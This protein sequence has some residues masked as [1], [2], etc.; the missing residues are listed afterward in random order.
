MKQLY[1]NNCV[2]IPT[3]EMVGWSRFLTHHFNGVVSLL[4]LLFIVNSNLF[5]QA[6][7]SFS[8]NLNCG[9]DTYCVD[10]EI[11]A[12]SGNSFDI[13]TSSFLVTYDYNALSYSSYSPNAF[14][15]NT[16]GCAGIWAAHKTDVYESEGKFGLTLRLLNNSGG[17]TL[18]GNTPTV[19]GT[20]CFD[21]NIQ[22]AI[23]NITFDNTNSLINSN[24]PDDGSMPISI[25]SIDTLNVANSL[26]C[27]CS[28]VGDPCDDLNVFTINDQYDIYCN[29]VGTLADV[30]LD[31]I[32]D[33][34]DNCLDVFYE[35]ENGTMNWAGF[36]NNQPQ[37]N[38]TGFVDWASK[39]TDTLVMSIVI[40]SLSEY[41]LIF[42]Y[43][44]GDATNIRR[45]KFF[46]DST[47]ITDTLAFPPTGGWNIWGEINLSDSLTADTHLLYL[48]S[49]GSVHGP[50]I[51]RIAIS[52]CGNCSM[53]GTPCDD[54]DPCTDSDTYDVDCNCKGVYSDSDKDG[55]CDNQDI[56]P[57][58]DDNLDTDMDGVPDAC[59]DCDNNLNGTSCDDGDPC[60]INDVYDVNC[61]CAGT[62]TGN[63]SDGDGVCDA[64]DACPGFDDNLDEDNDG[65]P[66]DCDSCNDLTVG[67]PCDDGNPCTILDVVTPGCGCGGIPI[68]LE[69]T[70]TIDTIKCNGDLASIDILPEHM[71]GGVYY[72]WNT[73]AYT[74]DLTNL[75]PGTYI[76][77]A[78]DW[79]NCAEVD[80]FIITEPSPI[81]LSFA[82]VPSGGSNGEIDLTVSGGNAPY[83]YLWEDSTMTQDLSGL[84]SDRFYVTVTD[85]L[86][87]NKVGFA[88]VEI[89][90]MCVDTLL[91][92]EYGTYINLQ[93]HNTN[94]GPAMDGFIRFGHNDAHSSVTHYYDF[95]EFGKYE[96]NIRHAEK[97]RN[98][99]VNIYL[100]GVLKHSA[101]YIPLTGSDSVFQHVTFTID[102]IPPGV[103]SIMTERA[104]TQNNYPRL[105]YLSICKTATYDCAPLE[106]TTCND[107]NPCTLNDLITACD[108]VGIYTDSDG[109]G[110]CD[111]DDVCAGFDDSI[112]SDDD[113]IPDGCDDCYA[114]KYE[115]ED[116][117]RISMNYRTTGSGWTG[118]GYVDYNS[119]IGDT[120]RFLINAELAGNYNIDLRYAI[121]KSDRFLDVFVNN[122]KEID[123]LFFPNTGSSN[124]KWESLAFN[125][126]LNAG[127]NI[128]ELITDGAHGPN[129]DYL[130]ICL[131]N[132]I[133]TPIIAKENNGFEAG[134]NNWTELTFNGSDSPV[135]NESTTNVLC[136]LKSMH[137]SGASGIEKLYADIDFLRIDSVYTLHFYAAGD[138]A[139]GYIGLPD[140]ILNGQYFTFD[141]TSGNGDFT[142]QSITFTA[143]APT[144]RLWFEF[145]P[146][147]NLYLDAFSFDNSN[148]FIDI[149]PKA[150]LSGAF[151]DA[152]NLM[153]D[154]LRVADLIPLNE[155]YT[156]LNNF[157][158][159]A[160]GGG[161]MIQN[162]VLHTTGND[163]IVDWVM[164]ELRDKNDSTNVLATK[165]AL[166]QRDGDIVGL[167][168]FSN[169]KF[170][171]VFTDDYYF[172]VRHR[173]HAG[174]MTASPISLGNGVTSIDFTN[175]STPTFGLNAQKNFEGKTALWS[176]DVNGDG[177]T[178]YNGWVSD[179]VAILSELNLANPDSVIVNKYSNADVNMDGEVKYN[180]TGNDREIILNQVGTST[181]NNIKSGNIPNLAFSL[182]SQNL[183]IRAKNNGSSNL[184]DVQLRCTT[185]PC[186]TTADA[187]GDLVFGLKWLNNA[188]ITL[189]TPTNVY[190]IGKS[191]IELL[192]GGYE[193]QAF[194]MTQLTDFPQNWTL[195]KWRTVT[196]LS[197]ENMDVPSAQVEICE[198][199]FLNNTFPN[200]NVILGDSSSMDYTPILANTNNNIPTIDD[201]YVDN[202]GDNVPNAFDCDPNDS[203]DGIL[204]IN[205]N[206]LGSGIYE[207]NNQIESQAIV[208][209]STDATFRAG[210][211]KLLPG[212]KVDNSQFVAIATDV[213]NEL[214]VA[215]VGA[216]VTCE[217]ESDGTATATATDG[218]GNYSYVW[219][220]GATTANLTDLSVG[221]YS[222]TIT[223][224]NGIIDSASVS[225]N[226]DSTDS[227]NDLITDGCDCDPNDASDGLTAVSDNPI[228]DSTYTAP[229]KLTSIGVIE[230]DTVT[231]FK[232]TRNILLLPGFKAKS[233]S[234]L[235]AI[236]EDVC[237]PPAMP[238]W[239]NEEDNFEDIQADMTTSDEKTFGHKTDPKV[240]F[241]PNPTSDYF[242]IRSEETVRG[243]GIYDLLGQEIFRGVGAEVYLADL[244]SGTYVVRVF[245][246]GKIVV[247]LIVKE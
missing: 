139:T 41:D 239:K 61:N 172:A 48:I 30:D 39:T 226:Y 192:S 129:I 113:G 110:V 6:E 35:A 12:T 18:V 44:N 170:R 173:N 151:D 37:Y 72:Q 103:H 243:Y 90:T 24:S 183:Q 235:V 242:Q 163:A 94:F 23:P 232:A 148:C 3:I 88:D 221:T 116:A 168:G 99:T 111:T 87:C 230:A 160:R 31:L 8:D 240:L 15:E 63:D 32:Y 4:F 80:T 141:A 27:D 176:G 130:T 211:V 214:K 220:T 46:I 181:P 208:T 101:L 85:A 212:F 162:S 36:K 216:D 234:H 185:E 202:D 54:G 50:N 73:G 22:G 47:L 171:T 21:V 14:D 62:F 112:D 193:Y 178:K 126:N 34:V 40:D 188:G 144:M 105:D 83:T 140:Q 5:A 102:S 150:F 189:G 184:I 227:D 245:F 158:H 191:D 155:P 49:H 231:V 124:A 117:V 180:G 70:P 55:I 137:Y 74:E 65:I 177:S 1:I 161:E 19:I 174:V 225:I 11:N 149:E 16:S 233:G 106:G 81:D 194:G 169:I 97:L 215:I 69:L 56:C 159:Q 118:S 128:I 154:S 66:N 75:S 108:C 76:V 201:D 143:T 209:N 91:Q 79:R 244:A 71:V 119:T 122:V 238:L 156:T 179:R 187:I 206:P 237:V 142:H 127:P 198:P 236:I 43:A 135:I 86:N 131:P 67:Q 53:A 224:G 222:V 10:L 60:T 218:D 96:F 104:T 133:Q 200:I 120:L 42:R 195:N 204:V 89:D 84:A 107:G 145:Y 241:V 82:T 203:S 246:D 219:N 229:N 217:G 95:P 125:W 52:S 153:H 247:G 64:N 77:T 93:S 138:S 157:D 114:L 164:L 13:G 20:V 132:L 38:G 196:T 190:A 166:I 26:A 7:L 152:I 123:S 59:D 51:D 100:D 205:D 223:D 147:T 68:Y 58:G 25:A 134:L 136:G 213:C 98:R 186:P 121:N 115:A 146:N 228:W 92:Y 199:D 2:H 210:T 17:C 207:N 167:D 109:D 45:L 57:D 33:G 28:G 165:S 175:P 78:T 9:N 197:V 182:P 29:C